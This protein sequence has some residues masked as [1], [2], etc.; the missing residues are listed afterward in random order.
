MADTKTA[1]EWI[2]GIR[3]LEIELTGNAGLPSVVTEVTRELDIWE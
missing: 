3:D 2:E 1:S